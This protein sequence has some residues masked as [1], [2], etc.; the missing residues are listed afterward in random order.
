MQENEE[1]LLQILKDMGKTNLS[2]I[3]LN[4]IVQKQKQEVEKAV[5]KDVMIPPSM[6]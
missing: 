2:D 4:Y 5:P 3:F 6:M 1:F